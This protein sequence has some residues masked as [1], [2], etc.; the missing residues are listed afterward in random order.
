MRARS[1]AMMVLGIAS[2]SVS[3]C[4]VD[5]ETSTGNESYEVD[6]RGLPCDWVTKEGNVRYGATWH[7]G[8]V[9]VDLSGDGRAVVEQRVVLFPLHTRQLDLTAS[10]LR[11]P[12]VTLRFEFDFY[13]PG[14]TTGDTFWDRDPV[15]L[16]TRSVDVFEHGTAV[17][18]RE[19]LIPSEAAGLVVRIVKE[20]SGRAMVDELTLGHS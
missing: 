4:V 1:V 2:I 15:F 7:D 6:C 3:A 11:D 14:S 10:I 9:G 8:D 17:V 12:E 19:V 13:A 20:G 18:H 16:V 5:A